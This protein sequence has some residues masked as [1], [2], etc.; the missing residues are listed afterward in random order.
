MT[1]LDATMQ[2]AQNVVVFG[3]GTM[4]AGIAGLYARGGWQVR[5]V[6]RRDS[7]I[8]QAAAY[9]EQRFEIEAGA[10]DFDT[11]PEA[12]LS[13]ADLV[14]E[15]IQESYE[16]KEALLK[17]IGSCVSASAIITTNT[18]SLDIDRLAQSVPEPGRFA[19]LHWFNPPELIEL[20]EVVLG[21]HTRPQ[22]GDDLLRDLTNLGK[23]GVLVRRPV[24]GFI[25]NRLQYAL[26]REAYDLVESGVCSWDDVDLAVTAGIGARWAAI[27]PFQSMDLAG[28]D[29]HA[30]VA[31]ELFSDLAN[32]TGVP[33]TLT[34][35]ISQGHL[36]CKSGEGLKGK[37]SE[38][39]IVKL[40]AMRQHILELLAAEHRR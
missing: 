16:A 38:E 22:V 29:V 24:K 15:T 36:G 31:S 18:S 8:R 39:E 28:L 4:G 23:T 35:L 13:G 19:G 27:G 32:S 37:Y 25:A 21:K 10:I 14:I 26:L 20:V 7:S 11:N 40:G 6:A 33:S 9:I 34:R 2:S 30:V 3:A 12:S 17:L 1:T 5:C